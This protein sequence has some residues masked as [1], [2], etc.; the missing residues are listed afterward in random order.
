MRTVYLQLGE[1]PFGTEG[2]SKWVQGS[3]ALVIRQR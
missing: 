2:Q 1:I 3:V